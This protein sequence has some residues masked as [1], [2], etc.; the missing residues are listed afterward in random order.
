[1]ADRD[2]DGIPDAED[3]CP[4]VP[5]V[6]TDNPKTNG[7]PS[8]RDGDGIPD[9]EDAC[10]D[11]AGPHTDDPKTNGCPK[12]AI[13]NGQIRINEQVKF[14][15]GS[16][17]ILTDS[18][19]LLTAVAQVMTDHPELKHVRV[20]G[21]TDN[22]GKAAMNKKLSRARAESVV[23]WLVKHSVAR[24]RLSAEGFGMDRPIDNNAT[25]LGRKNNRR[26]EFHI[27]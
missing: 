13:V 18:D 20:E 26:V 12:A 1:V 25:E 10:P 19:E 6:K 23:A 11:A 21:H 22:V 17:K 15:T 24:S 4:D 27:E 14:A 5:G 8:D 16:A 2:G 7:C 3:A 9:T